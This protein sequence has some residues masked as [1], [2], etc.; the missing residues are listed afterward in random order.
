[1]ARNGKT[2]PW[3]Y[4]ALGCLGAAVAAILVV[5]GLGFAGW[6]WARGLEEQLEDPEARTAK[7]LEVLGAERVP[8]GYHAVIALEI[9]FLMKMAILSDVPP[10]PAGDPGQWS[11]DRG[12]EERGLIFFEMPSPLVFLAVSIAAL[13]AAFCFVIS[14]IAFCSA[15]SKPLPRPAYAAS[16]RALPGASVDDLNAST[17]AVTSPVILVTSA[18]TSCSS[19]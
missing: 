1:M 4:V 19:A 18:S 2:S 7:V 3:V 9:P 15:V 10:T 8:D 16:T 17:L 14:A 13:P 5:A 12:F 11:A 6:R